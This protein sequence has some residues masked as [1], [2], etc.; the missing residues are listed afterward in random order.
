M[1]NHILIID[2]DEMIRTDMAQYLKNEGYKVSAAGTGQKGLS[3]LGKEEIDLVLLDLNL[4][5]GDGLSIEQQ[6]REEF[7]VPI[8]IVTARTGQD[9]KLMALSLGANEYLTK[10]VDAK[11]LLLRVRNLLSLADNGTEATSPVQKADAVAI[12]KALSLQVRDFLDRTRTD[13]KATD[14][15]GRRSYG[16]LFRVLAIIVVVTAGGGGA[17]WFFG[18]MSELPPVAPEQTRSAPDKPSSRAPVDKAI[19]RSEAS[20][21]AQKTLEKKRATVSVDIPEEQPPK[22]AAEETGYE[23]ALKSKCDPIPDIEW[24]KNKT[25]VSIA[26]YVDRKHG[27]E[28][29]AYMNQWY[30]RLL[31]LQEIHGRN[32]GVKSSTG[33]VLKGNE[34]KAYIKK[35]RTRLSVIRCLAQEAREFSSAK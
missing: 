28:W 34:L 4:P 24:W 20:E 15:T 19:E 11:E 27:G 8:I 2:D 3:V 12:K 9:D 21:P 29:K 1:K 35:M 13:H 22:P 17:F 6:V 10:P 31:K 7:S 23:W 18:T 33:V 32:S 25:H 30:R 14:S 26:A 16:T 5:D